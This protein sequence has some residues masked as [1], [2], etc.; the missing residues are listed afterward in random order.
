M[1][2]VISPRNTE[3]VGVII[4]RCTQVVRVIRRPGSGH[5]HTKNPFEMV[6]GGRY[7][8]GFLGKNLELVSHKPRAI[9]RRGILLLVQLYFL[10][11]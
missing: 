10:S 4:F 5:S 8:V 7:W 6:G 11:K 9:S 1:V 3:V 2:V